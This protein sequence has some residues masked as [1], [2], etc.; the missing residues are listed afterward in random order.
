[1]YESIKNNCRMKN[2]LLLIPALVI[3]MVSCKQSAQQDSYSCDATPVETHALI[4]DADTIYTIAET[5]IDQPITVKGY[6]THVCS[7][8]GKRCFLTGDRQQHSIRVE[9]MGKIGRFDQEQV[10]TLLTIEGVL[11]ERRL[12]QTEIADM[13]REVNLKIE[14]QPQE[15]GAMETCEAELANINEMKEWMQARGKDYYSIYYID[16]LQYHKTKQ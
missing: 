12:T 10:G 2:Y 3:S 6:A 9:A 1:M 13:E 15:E 16:G 8:S 7:H 5:F 4:F 14:E 11:R